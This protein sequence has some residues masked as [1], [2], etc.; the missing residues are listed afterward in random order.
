MSRHFSVTQTDLTQKLS[1]QETS[2]KHRQLPSF[3]REFADRTSPNNKP[4]KVK[5]K[6]KSWIKEVDEY[7]E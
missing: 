3:G 7:D 5:E 2:K 1:R 4:L 6:Y